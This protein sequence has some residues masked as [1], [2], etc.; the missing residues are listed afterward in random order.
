MDQAIPPG[1]YEHFKGG[2]YEVLGTAR[3]SETEQ[4]FVV[5]ETGTEP[6]STWIRPLEMF[7]Q[8]VTRDGVTKPRFRY[9]CLLYTSPSPRDRG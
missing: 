7:Q 3:H 2:R 1:I 9:L 5:Y 6:R 8:S 4:C